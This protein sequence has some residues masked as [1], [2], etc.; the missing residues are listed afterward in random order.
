MNNVADKKRKRY[1][2]FLDLL[3]NF[4]LVQVFIMASHKIK[5]LGL[6]D[7]LLKFQSCWLEFHGPAL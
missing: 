6:Q 1:N 4:L 2:I 5:D 3:A 7:T